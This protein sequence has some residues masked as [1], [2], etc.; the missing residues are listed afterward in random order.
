[1]VHAWGQLD[2]D[3]PTGETTSSRLAVCNI[4]WDRLGAND[5]FSELMCLGNVGTVKLL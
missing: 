5:I 4:D 3:C 2:T 1:M